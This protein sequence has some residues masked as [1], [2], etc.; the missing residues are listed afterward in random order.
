M[1]AGVALSR[2]L[3]VA[4]LFLHVAIAGSTFASGGEARTLANRALPWVTAEAN[5]PGVVFRAFDSATVGAK[6]SYHAYL[7]PS[8][9]NDTERLPVLYWLH[10][11]G[12]GIGGIPA[13]SRFFGDA[14][15][16]GRIPTMI[17]VF[18]NG[19]SRSLWADSKDG[20]APVETVFLR[21]VI[22]DVDRNFRTIAKR[23]GR[24]LEGFSMGGYGAARIG[25]KHPELFAG[26][27]ILAGGP[28]DLELQGPRAQRNP[29]LREAILRDVCGNDM[30]YFRAISPW[31]IAEGAAP[32]LRERPTVIRQA[33]GEVD[34]TAP[35]NRR[36]HIR[37]ATLDIA[38]D[39]AEVP[40]VGHDARALLGALGEG[41]GQFYR[42]AL[43]LGD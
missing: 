1:G 13:V 20:A 41:N 37:L 26:I 31:V 2:R 8:Y 17:V 35:L 12:G 4:S 33:V 25:L 24:I 21:E 7:P 5:S 6:V 16:S 18:V 23:E 15:S 36:F 3:A 28:F 30:A 29:R 19:L 10:G 14:M 43:G 38:H 11:T 32:R 39:Y 42:R 22:P 27:S 40:R 34:D 9:G